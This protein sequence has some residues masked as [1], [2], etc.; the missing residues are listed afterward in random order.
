MVIPSVSAPK[1][2]SVTPFMGILFPLLR[3][4]EV[5][6]LWSPFLSFMCFAN[7]ILGIT[8]ADYLTDSIYLTGSGHMVDVVAHL[9]SQYD[10]V[11]LWGVSKRFS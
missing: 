2:V 8:K 9:Y 4:I 5:F 11:C 7:C 1:F 10:W 6:T 3:R